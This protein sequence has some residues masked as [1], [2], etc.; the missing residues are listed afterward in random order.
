MVTEDINDF[1]NY[2]KKEMQKDKFD[3]SL[4]SLAS[5][6]GLFF[7][8]L[9]I[10]FGKEFVSSHILVALI[11]V[12]FLPFLYGFLLGSLICDNA[13]L[14]VKG[15]IYLFYGFP[16]YLIYLS[17]E[18]LRSNYAGNRLINLSYL[19]I[20]I[21]VITSKWLV[22]W[23]T[24]HIFDVFNESWSKLNSTIVSSTEVAALLFMISTDSTA[25]D[26]FITASIFF[27]AAGIFL[28]VYS[29]KLF[30]NRDKPFDIITKKGNL[31]IS[32]LLM[33][34]AVITYILITFY[35]SLFEPYD[36]FIVFSVIILALFLILSLLFTPKCALKFKKDDR[37]RSQI[38]GGIKC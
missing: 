9:E 18:W 26:F 5:Y 38:D 10:L 6:I 2:V 32:R 34:M 15:W 33:K 16:M 12:F 11:M 14:R 7:S 25:Y 28:E 31:K 3:S 30:K 36:I 37:Y 35:I 13:V 23:V 21:A 22:K 1:K 27:I 24:K 8:F 17:R 29:L 4:L 19:F 20:L